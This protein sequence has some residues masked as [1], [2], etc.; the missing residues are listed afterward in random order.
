LG[1]TKP[2]K[3]H[4]RK[5]LLLLNVVLVLIPTAYFG[6]AFV[7]RNIAKILIAGEQPIPSDAIV[8]L[9]GDPG[10]AVEAADLFK[11][12][13]APYVLLTTEN[14]PA[15]YEKARKD[16][17]QLV[18]NHENYVRLLQGYGVPATDIFRVE[19][20]VGDTYDEVSRVRDFA[21]DKGW[22][23]LTIVTS[24]FHTRRAR[25]VARYLLQPSM[26]VTVVSSQYDSFKPESWWTSQAQ[27]RMFGIELQKLITYSL[28]IWPRTLWNRRESTKPRSTSSAQPDLFLTPVS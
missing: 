25:M 22:T 23:R 26:R 12:K 11:R 16:G 21:R 10:R 14:P 20:Y 17:I 3:P 18:L 8:V 19:S 15:V 27:M 5:K 24:N 28:Y 13:I 4:T 7:L 6:Y 1:R 9:A 2:L